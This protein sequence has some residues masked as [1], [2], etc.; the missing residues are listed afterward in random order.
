MIL[1]EVSESIDCMAACRDLPS[2]CCRIMLHAYVL[3]ATE[4]NELSC[5]TSF[6]LYSN[7]V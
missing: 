2:S 3:A 1:L 5:Q 7:Q 4:K 6:N